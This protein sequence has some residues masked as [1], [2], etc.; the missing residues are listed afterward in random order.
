MVP[1]YQRS[2]D[3]NCHWPHFRSKQ[4][5]WYTARSPRC[6][7]HTAP[8][9][10]PLLSVPTV[11]ILYLPYLYFTRCS[12]KVQ[13]GRVRVQ[14]LYLLYPLYLNS[15]YGP[16]HLYY[17]RTYCRAGKVWKTGTCNLLSSSASS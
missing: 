3:Q 1:C 10:Y 17:P 8:A 16:R 11:P 4:A 5:T 7:T 14:Q 9:L 6:C 12:G 2:D 15:T 13:A